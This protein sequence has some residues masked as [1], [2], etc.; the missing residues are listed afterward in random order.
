MDPGSALLRSSV[1]STPILS[2]SMQPLPS[3]GSQSLPPTSSPELVSRP[4]PEPNPSSST[5][6]AKPRLHPVDQ[7]TTTLSEEQ[8]DP[9]ANSI[10]SVLDLPK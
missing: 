2:T 6:V 8:P 3:D 4:Y 1:V 7:P 10:I 5:L 9:L